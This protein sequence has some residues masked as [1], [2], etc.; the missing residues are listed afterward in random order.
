MKPLKQNAGQSA[1]ESVSLI[2]NIAIFAGTAASIAMFSDGLVPSHYKTLHFALSYEVEFLKRGLVGEVFRIL[3]LSPWS[4]APGIFTLIVLVLLGGVYM[5]ATHTLLRQHAHPLLGLVL[6][7]LWASPAAIPHLSADFGRFDA[8]LILVL[9][10]WAVCSYALSATPSLMLLTVGACCSVLIHEVAL[11]AT[12]PIGLVLWLIRYDEPLVSSSTVAFSL[13]ISLT[14][15][16]TWTFGGAGSLDPDGIVAMIAEH[17]GPSDYSIELM[18]LL[19]FGGM[20][21]NVSYSASYATRSAPLKEHLQFVVVMSGFMLL[22]GTMVATAVRRLP[23]RG[24]VAIV[25]C[26]APL[27]LYPF[28]YDYFRWLS[29]V[30]INMTILSVWVMLHDPRVT[31][32]VILRCENWR[33][34]IICLVFLFLAVGPVGIFTGFSLREA[35]L[36]TLLVP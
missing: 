30:L 11:F 26:F 24:F 17:Y 33:N 14:F 29:F 32:A 15:A 8:L 18:L 1:R 9:G 5:I 2:T 31:E 34:T 19:L 36:V 20:P 4:A 23:I 16:L 21:E 28:G 35:P 27:A 6:V 13:V 3:G 12:V 7:A 25:G 10:L 22:L